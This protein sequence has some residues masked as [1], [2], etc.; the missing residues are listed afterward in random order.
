MVLL[1]Q[2]IREALDAY[3][4][5]LSTPHHFQLTVA[6]PAGESNYQTMHLARMNE[7]LD[8]WNLMAFDY[9]GS[10]S[11]V[12][13]DQA[14]LF[15]SGQDLATTPFDTQRAVNYYL[16]QGIPSKRIVLGMPVYGRSFEATDGLGKPYDGIGNG[17]WEQAGVYDFK[18]LP[19]SGAVE[20]YDQATGASYSY[21]AGKR[22]L[23]SYDTV[24]VA[25]QKAAY[26]QQ[27]GLGGA[28]WWESSADG[29]GN[30]SLI[31]NVVEILSG[32]D[33]STLEHSPNQLSYPNSTYD[34]LRAGVPESGSSSATT[35]VSTDMVSG[36]CLSRTAAT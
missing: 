11:S 29:V 33:G 25:K 22:E 17:N 18:S 16:S 23:I 28:M 19:L 15:P 9:S 7:Y 14:N 27:K 24:A 12:A 4:N 5:S 26:I 2:A 13:A 34:N 21:D 30:N 35:P 20:I 8:F 31:Q 6:C 32:G 36:D 3:G 10:W 1:L